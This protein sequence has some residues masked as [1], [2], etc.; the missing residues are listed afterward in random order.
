MSKSTILMPDNETGMH[1]VDEALRYGLVSYDWSNAKGIW[2]KDTPMDDD[3]YLV[4][5]VI[6]SAGILGRRTAPF[7]TFLVPHRVPH[8]FTPRS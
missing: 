3:E 6:I 8:G 2:S 1:S 7:P 4:R 5:Q